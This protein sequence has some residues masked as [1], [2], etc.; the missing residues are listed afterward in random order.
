MKD[1]LPLFFIM[2][3]LLVNSVCI[4]TMRKRNEV[5]IHGT[6]WMN[7]ENIMLDSRTLKQRPPFVWFDLYECPE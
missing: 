1:H 6:A 3:V 5:L 4:K 7:L 2:V